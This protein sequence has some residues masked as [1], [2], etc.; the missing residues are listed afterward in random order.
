MK[1]IQNL[2]SSHQNIAAKVYIDTILAP[3][4]EADQVF[5]K[6]GGGASNPSRGSFSTFYFLN[7]IKLEQF[8]F[9]G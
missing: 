8:G 1:A 7:Y 5:G 6:R 2:F 9:R 4:S 3:V